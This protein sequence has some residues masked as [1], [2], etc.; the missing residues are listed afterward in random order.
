MLVNRAYPVVPGIQKIPFKI[1]GWIGIAIYC[2]F[3]ELEVI[4]ACFPV[5]MSAMA[6]AQRP[7]ADDALLKKLGMSFL[8]IWFLAS[9]LNKT[10]KIIQ[11]IDVFVNCIYIHHT[12]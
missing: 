4:S 9:G 5:D 3:Y 7:V 1:C 6:G 10:M 2:F 12:Q 8:P 11:T